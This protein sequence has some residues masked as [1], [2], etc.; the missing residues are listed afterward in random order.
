VLG[1]CLEHQPD[2]PRVL[3]D[4]SEELTEQVGQFA[5]WQNCEYDRLVNDFAGSLG[6]IVEALRSTVTDNEQIGSDMAK[7]EEN[8]RK[9]ST[10]NS[11]EEMR[12]NLSKQA[13]TLQRVVKRHTAMQ[14]NIKREHE[15]TVRVLSAQLMIAESHGRTDALTKLPN[16]GAFE[17]EFQS[18]LMQFKHGGCEYS[19]AITDLDMFKAIND[20]LG[21]PAGDASLVAFAQLLKE[22]FGGIAFIAR[23]GGDEFVVLYKGGL[24][25]LN[26]RM[27]KL[28]VALVKRPVFYDRNDN[29]RK[30]TL[31]CSFGVAEMTEGDT[32]ES[33][34]RR[35]DGSLYEMKRGG[36]DEQA[37]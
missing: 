34:Y 36:R 10:L 27:R 18:A 11:I 28:Q 31:A 2:K 3:D 6:R 15:A 25:D 7:V 26:Q 13:A 33:I 35:A 29:A 20:K 21:H 16:R 19:L 30:V 14:A 23:L 22:M 24:A 17:Q 32:P 4:L 9:A 1:K 8:L 12:S 37:A 5:Q